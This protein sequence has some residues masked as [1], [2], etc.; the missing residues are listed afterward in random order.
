M[1]TASEHLEAKIWLEAT[2]ADMLDEK[3]AEFFA[4]V[5]AY[6]AENPVADRGPDSLAVLREDNVAFAKILRSIYG[7]EPPPFA[8]PSIESP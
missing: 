3:R 4:A 8:S 1:S 2:V 6:Y 5:N 7:E